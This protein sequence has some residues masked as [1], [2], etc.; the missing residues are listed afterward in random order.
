MEVDFVSV[1]IRPTCAE[2]NNNLV[3]LAELTVFGSV[4]ELTA[5]QCG[6]NTGS[7]LIALF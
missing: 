1:N 6:M 3:T 2:Q 5:L 4:D 7:K